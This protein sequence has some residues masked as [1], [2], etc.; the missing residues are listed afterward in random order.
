[1]RGASRPGRIEER[2]FP[3]FSRMPPG[4]P[5]FPGAR[6]GPRPPESIAMW[7]SDFDLVLTDRV[8]LGGA[9]RIEDG[10]IAEVR[11][12]PVEA[13]TIYGEGRLLLPGFVDIHGDMVERE[14]EPRP[15]VRMPL[16]LSVLEHD[17]KL[18]AT[19]I[20]TAY[21]SLSFNPGSMVTGKVRAE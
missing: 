8:V 13:A 5:G 20:T 15:G 18:A 19:G 2:R 17:K 1:M 6:R 12:R 21:A 3:P 7:L 10:V 11:E 4:E 16:D 9:V 14:V